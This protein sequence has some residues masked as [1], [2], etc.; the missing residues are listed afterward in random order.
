MFAA[1]DHKMRSI[2]CNFCYITVYSDHKPREFLF[3][4]TVPD[5]QLGRWAILAQEYKLRNKYLPGKY[6]LIPDSFSRIEGMCI[7]AEQSH[8]NNLF[9]S[10]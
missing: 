9:Q 1:N 4:G 3:R 8:G 2:S 5:R 10:I 7:E 6:N